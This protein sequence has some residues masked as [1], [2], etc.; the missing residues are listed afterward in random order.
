[1]KKDEEKNAIFWCELLS[2]IIYDEIDPE[3]AHRFLKALSEKEVRFPDG[4]M[5]KPALTTLRRKLER[6]RNGGFDSLFRKQRTDRGKPRKVSQEVLER[7]IELKKDQPRRSPETI[8]RF[9]EEMHGVKIPTSTLYRHLKR[10]HA[11]RLKLGVIQEKVRK[12]WSKD[13]SNDMWVGDFENG[14]YVKEKEDVSATY[15]SAF[16][17]CHSRYVVEARYYRRQRL[18][19]LVDSVI[20]ALS[21]HGAPMATYVDNAKVYHAMSLRSA[22]YRCNIKLLHRPPNEPQTGG[23]IERFFQTVQDQF[24]AEVRAGDILTLE[25]LN[26]AFFAWLAVSYHKTIHSET[27]ET[28][29]DR[30]QKGIQCVRRVDM[31]RVIE[32]FMQS[33]HRTVNR[34]FSDVRIENRFYRVDPKLRGDRVDVRFDPF[35]QWDTVQIYSLT[36]EYLGTGALHHRD[37]NIPVPVVKPGKPKYSYT[38]LLIRKHKQMLEEQTGGID[39]SSAIKPQ[40]F[41]FHEFAKIIA[42][43]LGRKNGLADLSTDELE[44]LKKLYQKRSGLNRQLVKKAFEKVPQRTIP[45]IIR[46][47]KTLIQQEV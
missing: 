31:N 22:C 39:Y 19:V 26:R 1:M 30:Y 28:P 33:I 46:E 12:R 34:V 20:R 18:D 47:I 6:Y 35:S 32:S 11:T 10:N 41:P 17:D 5:D 45:Y 37:T 25:N 27:G 3:A 2:P 16:I 23:I 24:E 7:A 4:H 44:A 14:P 38:E 43:Y 8:N 13:H 40:P 29:E 42:D 36:G 21:R 9:L 15:L